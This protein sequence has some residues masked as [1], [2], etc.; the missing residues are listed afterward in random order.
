[1]VLGNLE[2]TICS[3]IYILL[4]RA[5]APHTSKLDTFKVILTA[6]TTEISANSSKGAL[7]VD[8]HQ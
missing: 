7:L 4:Q 3:G 6:D 8:L 2:L 1:M 5:V